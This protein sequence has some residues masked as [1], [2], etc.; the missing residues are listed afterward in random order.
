MRKF[1]IAIAVLFI[2]SIANSQVLVAKSATIIDSLKLGTARSIKS[3]PWVNVRDYGAKGDGITDDITAIRAA[4]LAAG[5]NGTI[6]FPSGYTFAVSDS[7]RSEFKGQRFIGYGATIKMTTETRMGFVTRHDSCTV[8]GFTIIG[9]GVASPDGQGSAIFVQ[10]ASYCDISDNTIISPS[11]SGIR[12]QE[13]GNLG[14]AGRPNMPCSYNIVT[15]N[16]I[17]NPLGTDQSTS[18]ILFGYNNQLK[19]EYNIIEN[20]YV[21]GGH[22]AQFGIGVIGNC[23]NNKIIKN[24]IKNVV[25]YGIPVYPYVPFSATDSIH[26]SVIAWNRIDSVGLTSGTNNFG[27]G[28]YCNSHVGG[29]IEGNI[30]TNTNYTSS[31]SSPLRLGGISVVE[32]SSMGIINNT[33]DSINVAFPCI[34]VGKVAD[35]NISGNHTNGGINSL[36]MDDIK[37]ISITDNKF[38]LSQDQTIISTTD[39]DSSIQII[40]NTLESKKQDAIYLVATA[41]KD[42]II[43]NNIMRGNVRGMIAYYFTGLVITDN[44]ITVSNANRAIQVFESNTGI[45]S[46]NQIRIL[47]GSA[48]VYAIEAG[49]KMMTEGNLVTG[50]TVPVLLGSNASYGSGTLSGGTLTINNTQVKSTSKIFVT[51]TSCSS[52]G[53]LFIGT[54]TAGTSFVVNSS[55]G[56]D[57]SAFNWWIVN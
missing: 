22:N 16:R 48:G 53:V 20:N 50:F 9:N 12:F 26:N 29:V 39:V 4:S 44:I 19:H 33:I 11:S 41:A 54:V 30:I 42:L 35:M 15:N 1:F 23:S 37:L 46:G 49:D 6:L 40:G 57:A 52:C 31:V 32:S 24:N 36:S 34:N 8:E 56:S 21:D 7:I 17:Y 14:I 47:D 13:G 55:N 5:R 51:L 3:F 10:G 38:L 25:A 18:G 43:S 27:S 28:I 2:S 45:I